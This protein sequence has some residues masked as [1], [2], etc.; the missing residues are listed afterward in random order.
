LEEWKTHASFLAFDNF[1]KYEWPKIDNK[2]IMGF[3]I[4]E[5]KTIGR[6]NTSTLAQEFQKGVK[7]DKSQYEKL[8][9]GSDFPRWNRSLKATAKA[10]GCCHVLDDNYFP[11]EPEEVELFELQKAFMYSVFDYTLQTDKGKEIVIDHEHDQDGQLVYQ[12]LYN[13]YTKSIDA[14]LKSDELREY[15]TSTTYSNSWKGNSST[16]IHHWKAKVKE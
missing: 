14:T 12:D 4:P 16:F 13:H 5:N 11:S 6:T 15:I 8:Q 9:R 2:A 1:K 10:H 3:S 7:R